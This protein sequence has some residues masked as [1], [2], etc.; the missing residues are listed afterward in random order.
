MIVTYIP[1]AQ[2]ST[3]QGATSVANEDALALNT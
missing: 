3:D 1:G 2:F